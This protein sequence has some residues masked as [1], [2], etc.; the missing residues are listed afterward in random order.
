[1]A[2]MSCAERRAALQA[3]FAAARQGD[4]GKIREQLAFVAATAAIDARALAA[5]SLTAARARLAR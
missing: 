4:G 5:R 1:M 3:A 2:C